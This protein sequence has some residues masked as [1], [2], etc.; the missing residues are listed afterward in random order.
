MKQ[1]MNTRTKR[2]V[3]TFGLLSILGLQMSWQS[4]P[5]S[6]E[7]ASEDPCVDTKLLP[8]PARCSEMKFEDKI[9]KVEY[10]NKKIDSAEKAGEDHVVAKV[11]LAGG[12]C[13]GLC[14]EYTFKATAPISDKDTDE[15][16][17][18]VAKIQSQMTEKQAN[19]QSKS[20]KKESHAS[21]DKETKASRA[22]DKMSEAYASRIASCNR[23]TGND[24]LSCYMD[25][26][27]DAREET[28]EKET[29]RWGSAELLKFYKDNISPLLK[30][31]MERMLGESDIMLEEGQAAREL[32]LDFYADLA[33]GRTTEAVRSA[34]MTD[35][36]QLIRKEA[37]RVSKMYRDNDPA[38]FQALQNF[39]EYHV[40]IDQILKAKLDERLAI[41]GSDMSQRQYQMLSTNYTS[42]LDRF[43]RNVATPTVDLMPK[44]TDG[45]AAL[46]SL[47]AQRSLV[48]RLKQS[49]GLARGQ[50]RFSDYMSI[51]QNGGAYDTQ[52]GV[53]ALSRPLQDARGS[54]N[55]TIGTGSRNITIPQAHR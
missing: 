15:V 33:G 21:A 31:R 41:E 52:R 39:R 13:G 44:I 8:R 32:A 40:G 12:E 10:Y 46:M 5:N 25:I 35:I 34:V 20:S 23:D 51:R 36:N 37:S 55:T 27:T 48:E 4:G 54:R 11:K 18:I 42:A 38:R 1:Q 6:S 7:M 49:A 29:A 24:R 30:A 43:I 16:T 3:M 19:L 50:S 28:N 45:S 14:G 22:S 17:K 47:D 26:V 53:G 2:L 9:Y